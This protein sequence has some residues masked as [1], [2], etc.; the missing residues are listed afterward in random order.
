[1]L[2]LTAAYFQ[3]ITRAG[4]SDILSRNIS[5]EVIVALRGA[6]LIA[7]GPRSRAGRPMGRCQ[8]SWP[9]CIIG[10]QKHDISKVRRNTFVLR[11][12]RRSVRRV[13]SLGTL[14]HKPSLNLW[15]AN[16]PARELGDHLDVLVMSGIPDI[17]VPIMH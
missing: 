9:Q 8:P 2:V 16:L 3:P 13:G 5:R 17:C 1:V 6:H 10:T 11:R 4:L 7:T 15:M 12:F 14:S